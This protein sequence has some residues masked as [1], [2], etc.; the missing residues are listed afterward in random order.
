[1]IRRFEDYVYRLLERIVRSNVQFKNLRVT[2][3]RPVCYLMRKRSQASNAWN[4][5]QMRPDIV[6]SRRG[7]SS[8]IAI[9]DTRWK[10]LSRL[11]SGRPTTSHRNHRVMALG[12]GDQNPLV[13]PVAVAQS[14]AD[15]ADSTDFTECGF[16]RGQIT[17]MTHRA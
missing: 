6:I 3:Q 17:R 13:C 12:P 4:F 15:R 2:A 7:D 8:P 9:I 5:L 11:E 14:A 10:L 1:M 16:W